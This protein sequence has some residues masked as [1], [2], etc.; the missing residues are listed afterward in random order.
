MK[1]Q[2]KLAIAKSELNVA[3]EAMN[4]ARVSYETAYT[5]YKKL[6]EQS[7]KLRLAKCSDITQLLDAST[8]S[9][10][11]HEKRRVFL[12]EMGLLS[13][14]YFM[15]SKQVCITIYLNKDECEDNEKARN[16]L[17]TILPYLIPI[18]F[19]NTRTAKKVSILESTCAAN[20]S[21]SL[22][23]FDNGEV[24]LEH[25]AYGHPTYTNL[26]DLDAALKYVQENVYYE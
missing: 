2:D 16:G 18:K 4:V 3:S 10:A 7:E 12:D 11:L 22:Y 9:M 26:G 19:K 8:D 17:K 20:G 25:M 6:F 14:G 13:S 24:K 21:Y 23:I 15:E 1:L 5:K